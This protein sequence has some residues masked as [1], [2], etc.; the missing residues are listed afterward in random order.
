[1]VLYCT[2]AMTNAVT[3]LYYC[4]IKIILVCMFNVINS[5]TYVHLCIHQYVL[6]SAVFHC[7]PASTVTL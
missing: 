5:S 1:M 3:T 4:I 2:T 6:H 7:V